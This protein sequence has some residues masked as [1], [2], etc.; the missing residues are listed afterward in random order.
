MSL[1]GDRFT[2]ELRS[3]ILNESDLQQVEAFPQKDDPKDR[4]FFDAKLPSCLYILVRQSP[5]SAFKV[6][7]HPGKDIKVIGHRLSP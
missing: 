4:V 7:T 2:Y 5:R 6:R 3:K 1:L